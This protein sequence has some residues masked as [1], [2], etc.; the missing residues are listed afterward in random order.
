MM[1]NYINIFLVFVIIVGVSIGS[2]YFGYNDGNLAGYDDGY[3]A[4]TY[5]GE[6]SMADICGVAVHKVINS[7]CPDIYKILMEGRKPILT[8]E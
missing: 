1:K 3:S 7:K 4:G 6:K 8:G 2:Y 5:D